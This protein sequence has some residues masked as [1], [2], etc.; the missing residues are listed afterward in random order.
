[1]QINIKRS[2]TDTMLK[3]NK[4]FAIGLMACMLLGSTK[5]LA[6]N[7][8]NVEINTLRLEARAD[9]FYDDESEQYGFAGRYF[10]LH[11]GGKL[12]DKVSYYF[13]Q[14]IIANPGSSQ[15]FDNTDFLHISYM[16][17]QNW[18]FRLGKDAIAVGGFE[19][20]AAPIDVY[21]NSIS[22]DNFYCFQLG[23]AATYF[24]NDG[25]HSFTANIANSPNNGFASYP[26]NSLSY[27]LLWSGNM[28]NWQ[29]LY[30][31]NLFEREQHAACDNL[32][33]VALGN[34]V[35]FD[36]WSL[37]VDLMAHFADNDICYQGVVARFDYHLNNNWNLFAKTSYEHNEG[38]PAD[39]FFF[40]KG[41]RTVAGVGF[42]NHPIYCPSLRYHALVAYNQMDSYIYSPTW[43]YPYGKGVMINMGISWNIDCMKAKRVMGL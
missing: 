10:N 36:N 2:Q 15:F 13:R 3:I 7:N 1:M 18:R 12:S 30:S 43:S 32:I 8:S 20:D 33:Y 40:G 14:R 24:S 4:L 6:Q 31:V 9:F 35:A 17:N 39:L 23:A 11:M 29:T 25:K 19:Y 27:N 16:P 5:V 26:W 42:E 38:N 41:T 37:Y 34:R 22:W 28:G 21:Y